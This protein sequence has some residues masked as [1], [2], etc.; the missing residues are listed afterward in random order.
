MNNILCPH[1]E[2]MQDKI[3][4]KTLI[5]N[6]YKCRTC[7]CYFD[8]DKVLKTKQSRVKAIWSNLQ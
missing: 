3:C 7:E 8:D 2:C 6:I 1:C 4:H 5:G